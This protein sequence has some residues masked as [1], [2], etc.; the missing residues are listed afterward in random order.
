QLFLL[1]LALLMAGR[2][3][4][5]RKVAMVLALASIVVAV[6]QRFPPGFVQLAGQSLFMADLALIIGVLAGAAVAGSSRGSMPGSP[7]VHRQVMIF[8]LVGTLASVLMWYA[9]TDI[10]RHA[11]S[12]SAGSGMTDLLAFTDALGELVLLVCLAFTIIMART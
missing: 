9:L 5:W 6:V 10:Y 8:G 1:A 4:S 3:S 11:L 2:A 7:L 12:A